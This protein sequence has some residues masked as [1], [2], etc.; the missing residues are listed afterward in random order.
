[1]DASTRLGSP[2]NDRSNLQGGP[3]LDTVRSREI[4]EDGQAVPRQADEQSGAPVP[5]QD[6]AP[7][8]NDPFILGAPVDSDGNDDQETVPELDPSGEDG[9]TY[10]R[11]QSPE[12]VST[13]GSTDPNNTLSHSDSGRPVE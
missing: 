5:S 3:D 6:P 4:S 9:P 1:M 2:D 8:A 11:N 13:G 12:D 7:S 10:E